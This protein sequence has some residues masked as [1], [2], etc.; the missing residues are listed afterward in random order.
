M[1]QIELDSCS[2]PLSLLLHDTLMPIQH[3]ANPEF[4]L[5]HSVDKSWQEACHILTMLKLAE[6]F[7]HVMI[8]A[9]LPYLQWKFTK[10]KGDHVTGIITKWFKPDAQAWA[11][12]A[13]W[14]PKNECVKNASNK[15]LE[16]ATTDMHNLYW[17]VEPI[18]QS[19]EKMHPKRGRI[20]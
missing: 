14:D 4:A 8:S 3:P 13:Y 2:S 7:A 5:F 17:E 16:C 6:L 10:E 15:M 9:L 12:N 11:T 19:S 1:W 18:P 20:S